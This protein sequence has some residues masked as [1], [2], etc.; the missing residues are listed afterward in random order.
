MGTWL[1]E[2]PRDGQN[3]AT[4]RAFSSLQPEYEC[5]LAPKRLAF[6][7]F[8]LT[9]FQ[10]NSWC[11]VSTQREHESNHAMVTTSGLPTLSMYAEPLSTSFLTA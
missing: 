11:L 1:S 7:D 3:D 5:H 6:W 8:A 4:A 2:L 9:S 10:R